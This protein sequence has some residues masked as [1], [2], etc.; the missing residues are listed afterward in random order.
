MAPA[1]VGVKSVHRYVGKFSNTLE[2]LVPHPALPQRFAMAQGRFL[3]ADLVPLT[4][5][6]G[7]GCLWKLS[8]CK[9][10]TEAPAEGLL[11]WAVACNWTSGD[12]GSVIS[13]W[14]ITRLICPFFN[15]SLLPT[16][17]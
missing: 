10:C 1:A 6:L 7:F 9:V 14:L 2:I 12:V 3:S 16:L 11:G 8:Y 5:Q 17:L 4:S 13:H 15:P